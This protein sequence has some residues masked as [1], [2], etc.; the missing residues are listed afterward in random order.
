MPRKTN[1]N[2]QRKVEEPVEIPTRWEAGEQLPTVYAN[3]L[4]ITHAG[5]EFYITFGELIPPLA[6]KKEELPDKI[7]IKAVA[8]IAV[9]REAMRAFAEVINTNLRNLEDK[10]KAEG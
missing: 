7:E 4:L 3:Q 1:P 2:G 5:P 9:S 10:I 8:R 6:L